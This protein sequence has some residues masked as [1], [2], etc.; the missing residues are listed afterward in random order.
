MAHR[1]RYTMAQ[2][3]L[4]SKLT[5]VVEVD[6]TYIGGKIRTGPQDYVKGTETERSPG[7]NR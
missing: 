7:R 1:I 5:G 4:S 2:E 3:P 6:E